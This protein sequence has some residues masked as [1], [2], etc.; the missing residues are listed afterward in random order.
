MTTT[1]PQIENNQLYLPDAAHPLC[2][3]GSPTWFAW[4]STATAFRYHSQKRHDLFHGCG[5]LLRPISVRKEKRHRGFLW[6]AYIRTHGILHKRYVGKSETLTLVR[7]DEI[8]TILD[9]IG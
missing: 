3:V 4:L 7:L 1:T 2:V 8:A 5:P 6:Y 9:E